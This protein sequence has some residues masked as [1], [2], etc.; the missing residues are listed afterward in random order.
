MNDA[1]ANKMFEILDRLKDLE[2]IVNNNAAATNKVIQE[3]VI[4]LE[5]KIAALEQAK[6]G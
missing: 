2:N 6:E 1:V 4:P 5:Q 3:R